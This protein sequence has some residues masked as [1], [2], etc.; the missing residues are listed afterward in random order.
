MN[1]TMRYMG[2]LLSMAITMIAFAL[3]IGSVVI[4]PSA[5]PMLMTSIT[6]AFCAFTLLGV[7]GIAASGM[8]G[9]IHNTSR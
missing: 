8:R 3:F 6:A 4:T 7:I 5:I 9:S 2:Q 1:A